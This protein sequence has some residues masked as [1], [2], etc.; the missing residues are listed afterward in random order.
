MIIFFLFK[1]NSSSQFPLNKEKDVCNYLS[2]NPDYTCE[3]YEC[4]IEAD[5]GDYWE[6]F[7]RCPGPENYPLGQSY[8]LNIEK[9]TGN[10]EIEDL[11]N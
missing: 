5:N 7:Y 4:K 10:I 2:Q 6:V 8:I 3:S 1:Q 11:T 9:K